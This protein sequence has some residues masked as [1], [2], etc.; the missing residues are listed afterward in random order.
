M[1]RA[2]AVLFAE[3]GCNVAIAE[4]KTKEANETLNRVEEKGGEG[5]AIQCEVSDSSRVKEAQ[6]CLYHRSFLREPQDERCLREDR[7]W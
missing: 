1:G 6:A 5:L 4:I 3:E 2:T 7:S